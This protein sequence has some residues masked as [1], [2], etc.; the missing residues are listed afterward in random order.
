MK[1]IKPDQNLLEKIKNNKQNIP[2]GIF[3]I[4]SANR[5][6]I[7]ASMQN[8]K[9]R[10][11][12]LLIEA[13]CNQVNQ[14]GGYTGMTP[15]D[16]SKYIADIAEKTDFPQ[17][18]ILLGGDHLGPYPWRN[19]P[20]EVALKN[21]EDLVRA[22][23]AAGYKKIHIDASMYCQDDD[24][25]QPLSKQLSADRAVCICRQA[26]AVATE[27]EDKPLYVIGTEV[28]LPGGQQE[29]NERVVVTGEDDV[30]E[31][32]DIFKE[33]FSRAKL[34]SAWE[35]VI[36]VVVQPGVE[37][38]EDDII[39]YQRKNAIH[40]KKFI[41]TVPNIAFE[42]H[43]TDYQTAENL[44]EMVEDHFAIL[45]VGPALTYRFREAVF[46]LEKIEEELFKHH[47]SVSLSNLRQTI[48]E[49]M[50]RSPE[51]WKNYYR[52]DP[53]LPITKL[54]AFS[55]R[56]R[57]YWNTPR[58]EQALQVLLRNLRSREIPLSLIDQYLPRQFDQI[59][60]GQLKNDPEAMILNHIIEEIA[61]YSYA[62]NNLIDK[63]MNE[64]N[65]KY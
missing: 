7:E 26:E 30:A 60:W 15:Q 34:E 57:Y 64:N 49:A 22:Y 11:S 16:F 14:F 3:S 17:E 65:H 41:E 54:F 6:V 55:D 2:D 36:A 23:V 48:L 51:N 56:I 24:H 25:T 35:R 61:R 50:D 44:R 31:T 28:P 10:D 33:A 8:A 12:F 43:S 53:D 52:G 13:T 47:S 4:C 62:C 29:A 40:L 59:R 39:D 38:G 58:V 37:F 18:R 45:K 20:G 21:S 27:N 9:E 63:E 46:S 19:L 1:T 5:Y 42:A 32:I